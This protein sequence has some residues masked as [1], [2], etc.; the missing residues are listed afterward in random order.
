MFE[1]SKDQKH[2]K[3]RMSL[4]NCFCSQSCYDLHRTALTITTQCLTCGRNVIKTPSERRASPSGNY[5]CSKS[6]AAVFNNKKKKK[7]RR[8]K[9]EIML[10]G[11]LKDKFPALNILPND[12]TMLDG[13]EIDIGIP[14]LK[15]GIEWNGVVH[16]KPIYGFAKLSRVQTIDAEKQKIAT[17][18][19]IHLIVVPDLVSTK[20]K[21]K[22]AFDEISK[23]IDQ[24][25]N[26]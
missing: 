24:L 7:S 16:F 18:K 5:F 21:V 26:L 10:C 3:K 4:K 19:G 25:L 15:L 23:I 9:C 1:P 6:C 8:S 11:M 22:E 13:L 2:D 17:Q 14:V 20:E 12:K